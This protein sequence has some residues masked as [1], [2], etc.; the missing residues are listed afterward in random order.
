MGLFGGGVPAGGPLGDPLGVEILV[1]HWFRVYLPLRD[2]SVSDSF[3]MS[4][5]VKF[6]FLP[7]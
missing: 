1:I 5:F 6:L 7:G 4:F 3:K 2:G